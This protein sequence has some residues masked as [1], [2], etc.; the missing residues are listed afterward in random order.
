[1][2]INGLNNQKLV[3]LH[4]SLLR[5]RRG[6]HSYE[7]GHKM[8]HHYEKIKD[9]SLLDDKGFSKTILCP[10]LILAGIR[11]FVLSLQ[12][13]PVIRV[14]SSVQALGGCGD[15]P[16]SDCSGEAQPVVIRNNC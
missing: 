7:L 14:L 16:V 11:S 1:M 2:F 8:N 5:R 15:C 3:G 10:G 13:P 12:P 6:R 9:E 4:S